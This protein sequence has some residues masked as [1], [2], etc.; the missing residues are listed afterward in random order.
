MY[1]FA[2]STALICTLRRHC[3]LG[4]GGTTRVGT[5]AYVP[6]LSGC[7]A[8]LTDP[9]Q[10]PSN[11]LLARILNRSNDIG[12]IR[13]ALFLREHPVTLFSAIKCP[14]LKQR[15]NLPR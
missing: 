14:A 15:P 4:S 9:P 10:L 8:D 13:N 6:S 12:R 7:W 2:S 11:M 1:C 5:A 3:S